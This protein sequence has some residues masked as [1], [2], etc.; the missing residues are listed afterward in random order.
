MKTI[1]T[2]QPIEQRA[3]PPA[4]APVDPAAVDARR[5]ATYQSYECFLRGRLAELDARRPAQWQRDYSGVDAYVRSIEPLRARLKA[6]L[7]FWIE[8]ADRPALATA[9]LET[10]LEDADFVARRFNMAVGEGLTTYAVELVPRSPG[11]HP[12]LLAQ[13]GYGGTPELIC[14]FTAKAN[15]PDYSYRSLGLR[16]VRRGFHVLAV[17]H[18][19]GYGTTADEATSVPNPA[20]VTH[21]NYGK[22]RLHRLAVMAGGTLFGLDMLASSRGIDWLAGRPGVD[23]RRIGMY[24]LSQGGESALYLPALDPR[25]RASV[26][27]AYFNSRLPKLIGPHRALSYLD[28]NEEDKFFTDV[29][30]CFSDADLVSLIAPRAF[31]VE[32]GLKD[33]SV[34]FEGAEAEYGRARV[35]YEKLGIPRRI[36]LIAHEEGHV[37][38][39]SRAFEFL[40][41][42]LACPM[43]N[44][45]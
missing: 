16:A 5:R 29:A 34:D 14:G 28:S 38:A 17:H 27:S 15:A 13:H 42:Q 23:P 26:C 45:Q 19:S 11:P 25:I 4:V 41:E 3:G 22:N 35:H 1:P 36:E 21:G 8:P 32:A 20:A 10:L 44:D 2:W 39:T 12:G 40:A 30:G 9:N 37:S 6:M 24:G 33:S 7:G 43:T 18:P 31:A